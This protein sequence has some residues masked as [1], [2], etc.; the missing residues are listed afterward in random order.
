MT[1]CSAPA[2]ARRAFARR[3]RRVLRLRGAF[4]A[5]PAPRARAIRAS[6]S[7]SCAARSTGFPPSR[8]SAIPITPICI[9]SSRLRWD[10]EHAALPLDDFFGL[11]PA[12]TNFARL[13]DA[14]QALVVHATATD[15]RERSH[16]DG[17]DVL[18]SGM[19]GP[20]MT[21]AAGSTAPSPRC[22]RASASRAARARGRLHRAAGAA[23]PGAD[24]RLGALGLD[25]AERRPRR[26]PDRTLRPRRSGA[27]RGAAGGPRRRPDGDKH[28]MD[29]LKPGGDAARADAARPRA[30][31][32]RLMAADDGP[33]IGA[34]AFDGWDT[35][36]DEGGATG[37]LAQLLGG[38]DGALRR[39]RERARRRA[40]RTRSS[41]PS[42]NSAAP[43]ASTAPSAPITAPRRSPSSRAARSP[44]GASSPTGPGLKP[45]P[46]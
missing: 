16:F 2:S 26:A 43:R 18:E 6:S 46:L 21:R 12:M 7:S 33:R 1:D 27:R 34:L 42:P 9:A 17:Q 28:G 11:N 13:Y 45:R 5:G 30:G 24:P 4:R 15:Y 22:P 39:L 31:A 8:R 40:G 35:H 25:A 32:A 41:S 23:R 37:R 20:A 38:L 14:K 19:P 10:G 44:A 3:R 36:A 29:A